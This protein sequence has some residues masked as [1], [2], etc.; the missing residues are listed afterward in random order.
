MIFNDSLNSSNGMGNFTSYAINTSKNIVEISNIT[1][2]EYGTDAQNNISVQLSVDNGENWYSAIKNNPLLGFTQDNS[3]VYR[4]I[5]NTN[6]TNTISLL[7]MNISWNYDLTNPNATLL[8][9]ENNTYTNISQQNLTVN[10]TDDYGLSNM[11]LSVYNQTNLINQTIQSIS[12]T[13]VLGGIIYIFAYDGIFN[14]FYRIFDLSGNTFNTENNTITIDT[15]YPKINFGYGTEENNTNF[16][17]NWIYINVSLIE[18]NLANITY[19]LYNSTGEVSS[20]TYDTPTE[21]INWTN[22]PDEIY[23]YNVSVIDKAGQFNTTETRVS[24]L[25][26]HGP[27]VQILYPEVKVYITNISLPLNYSVYDN[28]IGVNFCWWNLDNQ[29]NQTISCG[30]NTTFNA[31]EGAHTIHVYANDSLRKSWK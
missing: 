23:Y 13:Q 24:R 25:D 18:D 27:S 30:T 12:G 7:D 19:G 17:R 14:W 15:T 16:T 2:D 29:P 4:V 21:E 3:L 11:T 5:F 1:W 28:L 31:S 20:I 10:V 6:S 8:T 9:P 26:Y 22:L